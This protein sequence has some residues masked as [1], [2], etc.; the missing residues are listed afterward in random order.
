MQEPFN[1]F[2]EPGTTPIKN[3]WLASRQ[4]TMKKR[5]LNGEWGGF[6]RFVFNNNMQDFIEAAASIYVFELSH[7]LTI[8]TK[9]KMT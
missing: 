1:G 6:V 9:I 8:F 2:Y 5:C 3:R 4:L 7:F